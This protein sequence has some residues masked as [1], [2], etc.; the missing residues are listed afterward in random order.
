MAKRKSKKKQV[1]KKDPDKWHLKM[2]FALGKTVK[3]ASRKIDKVKSSS[4][5]YSA[6]KRNASK[7]MVTTRPDIFSDI[8]QGPM[9]P[10]LKELKGIMDVSGLTAAIQE[11]NEIGLK[12]SS[13]PVVNRLVSKVQQLSPVEQEALSR[14]FIGRLQASPYFS[15]AMFSMPSQVKMTEEECQKISD[16]FIEC[17]TS[18]LEDIG[19]TQEEQ[20]FLKKFS[21]DMT[22]PLNELIQFYVHPKTF[23]QKVKRLWRMQRIIIKM[24]KLINMSNRLARNNT[25]FLNSAAASS[26]STPSNYWE[27]IGDQPIVIKETSLIK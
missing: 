15:N 22:R 5:G 3:K 23:S 16:S 20:E 24:I 26:A 14:K 11:M 18:T 13:H 21:D 8:P 2:A 10:L 1:L 12:H 25:E 7:S 6:R 17:V 19:M 4:R 27:N 9:S